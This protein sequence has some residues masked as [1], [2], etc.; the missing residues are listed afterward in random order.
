MKIF[1]EKQVHIP[2]NRLAVMIIFS[3]VNSFILSYVN[4]FAPLSPKMAQKKRNS[5][6]CRV[7]LTLFLRW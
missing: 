3:I 2:H 5:G 4:I 6:V 1:L 7:Y